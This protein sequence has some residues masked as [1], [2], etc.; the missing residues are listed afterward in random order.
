VPHHPERTDLSAAAGAIAT[1]V[2]ADT[3]RRQAGTTDG[4]DAVTLEEKRG[5]GR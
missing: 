1:R 4:A 5:R 2:L 3:L